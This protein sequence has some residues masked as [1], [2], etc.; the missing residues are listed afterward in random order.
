MHLVL[1]D[2]GPA[3]THTPLHFLY[4]IIGDTVKVEDIRLSRGVI[5]TFGEYLPS[6]AILSVY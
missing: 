2:H 1:F 3:Y 5:V 4:C 6:I